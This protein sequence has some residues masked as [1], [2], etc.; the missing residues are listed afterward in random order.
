[1][2]PTAM[3]QDER[4]VDDGNSKAMDYDELVVE[5]RSLKMNARSST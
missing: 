1:M 5:D 3:N 4:E 2:N